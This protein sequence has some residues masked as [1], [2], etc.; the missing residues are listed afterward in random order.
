MHLF[1]HSLFFWLLIGF[2][3]RPGWLAANGS[4]DLWNMS[5]DDLL[6]MEVVTASKRAQSIEEAPSAMTVIT[7]EDIRLYGAMNI[8]EALRLVPGIEI[9]QLGDHNYEV[10][11]RGMSRL[12]YNT[13]NKLLWLVNGRSVYNDAFGGV[14][15]QALNVNIDDVERIEVVRGPGSALYG[16]NAFLGVINIITRSTRE[17][18]GFSANLRGGNLGFS[19]PQFRFDG[20]LS[21]KIRFRLSGQFSNL[22]QEEERFAGLTESQVDSLTDMGHTNGHRYNQRVYQ[23]NGELNYD[24]DDGRGASLRFGYS[25]NT[26][27]HYYLIPAEIRASDYFGQLDFQDSANHLRFYFNGQGELNYETTAF[28]HRTIAEH[29]YLQLTGRSQVFE[30][31]GMLTHNL[32]DAEYSRVI[33]PFGRLSVVGGGSFRYNRVRSNLFDISGR[34]VTKNEY[35]YALFIQADY[36]LN[37]TVALVGGARLDGHSV[38]S[39]SLNPRLTMLIK[40]QP[41]MTARLSVGQATRNPHFLDLYMD[42]LVKARNLRRI[43]GLDPIYNLTMESDYITLRVRGDEDIKSERLISYE[44][45]LQFRLGAIAHVQ[46]DVFYNRVSDAIQFTNNI[47]DQYINRI[48]NIN[49][50]FAA[51]GADT[52]PIFGENDRLTEDEMRQTI[53]GLEQQI[54]YLHSIGQDEMAAQWQAVVGGLNTLLPLYDVPK[55][56]YSD[57]LNI[58]NRFD[59]YGGEI[60]A[61]LFVN[62]HLSLTANY[63]HLQF[64]DN[65]NTEYLSD[66]TP[67]DLI[68][69]PQHKLNLGVKFQYLNFYG[70]AMFNYMSKIEQFTDNNGDAVFDINDTRYPNRGKNRVEDRQNLSLNLGYQFTFRTKMQIDL[71]VSG[72]NLVQDNYT[73]VYRGATL[74]GGDELHRRYAGGIR[75]TY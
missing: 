71:F 36:A 26:A 73:Q 61:E 3:L 10:T 5:L 50:I 75:L 68:K 4:D 63:A 2:S 72:Q 40:P 38:V 37:S 45:G 18:V 41:N 14:R 34:E 17:S 1:K 54:A 28:A 56:L 12:Q 30:N 48:E 59:S 6:N 70:G 46:A 23:I 27:D 15:L 35:L 19:D 65:F 62:K 55:T 74:P 67:V 58:D 43:T 57:M 7:A 31:Q 16:A 51:L 20:P 52:T 42:M 29:P 47:P 53:V 25:H 32:F 44:A 21:E 69:S 66:R 9:I 49:A 60:S 64:D 13:S 8:G 39:T 24:I 22:K 33:S 11:I